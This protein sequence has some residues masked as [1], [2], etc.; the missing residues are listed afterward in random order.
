MRKSTTAANADRLDFSSFDVNE[1]LAVNWLSAQAAARMNAQIGQNATRVQLELFEFA[2]RR[3]T[4]NFEVAKSLA[5]DGRL[6]DAVGE[7][8]RF[9]RQAVADYAE[10]ARRLVTLCTAMTGDLIQEI[11]DDVS[12]S[13]AE[14][15]SLAKVS[16]SRAAEM[17][18]REIENLVIGGPAGEGGEGPGR[19]ASGPPAGD[20]SGAPAG[21][22]TREARAAEPT[23]TPSGSRPE[24]GEKMAATGPVIS[25]R[26]RSE[27]RSDA[28]LKRAIVQVLMETGKPM[29]LAEIAWQIGPI[30]YAAL[31]RP[32]RALCTMARVVK[33]DKAYRLP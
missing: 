27:A 28:D 25:L 17:L 23:R 22:E 13:A 20:G 21:E 16:T 29:T 19:S 2:R 31:I 26:A 24:T 3:L 6:E 30:H 7:V 12:E 4:A 9:H 1:L 10:Q 5:R 18:I 15:G 14:A 11:E 33:D 32:M 8:C